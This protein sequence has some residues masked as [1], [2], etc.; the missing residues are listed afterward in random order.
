MIRMV[1]GNCTVL[2]GTVARVYLFLFSIIIFSIHVSSS[3]VITQIRLPCQGHLRWG[4]RAREE[5]KIKAVKREGS[6][7]YLV[8]WNTRKVGVSLGN[9]GVEKKERKKKGHADNSQSE[10]MN[11]K[12]REKQRTRNITVQLTRG[13]GK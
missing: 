5:K 2:D 9:N 1:L 11:G 13:R 12:R 4:S 8:L 7:A 3:S 10:W 6:K